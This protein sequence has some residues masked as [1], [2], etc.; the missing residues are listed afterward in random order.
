[1]KLSY[2]LIAFLLFNLEVFGQSEAERVKL[3]NLDKKVGIQGYDPVA[4]QTDQDAKRGKKSIAATYKGVTYYFISEAN[5][6][7]FSSNPSKYEPAYGGWCAY[8]MGKTGDKVKV[9]PET[10]KVIDGQLY[11]FYNFF[12]NNTLDDWNEDEKALKTMAKQNWQK[13]LNN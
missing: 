5:K 2:L 4:Y 7:M 11:L 6:Q 1:M 3:F 13:L 10:F 9:D 8:A 12:F